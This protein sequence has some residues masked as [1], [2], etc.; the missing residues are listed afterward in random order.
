[1]SIKD[2]SS[3]PSYSTVIS[4]YVKCGVF[5]CDK[6]IKIIGKG[7]ESIKTKVTNIKILKK[8]YN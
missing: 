1:M 6:D 4:S 7:S 2:V 5:K 8:S 3:I